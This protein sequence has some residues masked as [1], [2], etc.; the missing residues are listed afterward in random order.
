MRESHY[1][2]PPSWRALERSLPNI[3]EGDPG[4]FPGLN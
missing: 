2:P 3:L 4:V 1:G